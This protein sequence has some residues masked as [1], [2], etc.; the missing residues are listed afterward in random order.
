ME[1]AEE[2]TLTFA[3]PCLIA[4]GIIFE[5]PL[6]SEGA[7]PLCET[8]RDQ[9]GRKRPKDDDDHDEDGDAKEEEWRWLS[10]PGCHGLVNWT[11]HG[12][13]LL[14]ARTTDERGCCFMEILMFST[15]WSYMALWIQIEAKQDAMLD[16][17]DTNKQET[18]RPLQLH[19][20]YTHTVYSH[21]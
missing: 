1:V 4:A 7:L 12:K 9:D 3:T 6:S 17:S 5:A 11:S 16:N 14:E 18:K 2:W 15:Q 20:I 19:Y 10:W 21:A 13:R 8:K